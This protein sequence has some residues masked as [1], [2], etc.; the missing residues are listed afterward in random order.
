[1][2]MISFPAGV[3]LAARLEGP[4]GHA[5]LIS[6]DNTETCKGLA[7]LMARSLVCVGSGERPCDGCVACEKA[8]RVS[9]P[10][11][12]TVTPAEGKREIPVATVRQVVT[13]APTLPNEAERKVYIISPAEAMNPSA[14]NAILKVLEEP[15]S[16]VTFLLLAE[17]P[18][19]LL[20]TVR[21]RCVALTLTPAGTDGVPQASSPEAEELVEEFLTAFHAG[22][23]E[24]L[25]F[26]V[27]LEKAVKED[28]GIL[29]AFVE[30]GYAGLVAGLAGAAGTRQRQMRAVTLFDS[31]KDD[32]KFNVSPGHISGKMLATL[33]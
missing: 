33:I 22:G 26:C 17:N 5:Y 4:L 8:Q 23:L 25:Q 9:H 21:S 18:L 2:N 3:R 11:I 16:F 32:L 7:A 27:G 20:P 30:L 29:V 31:F 13:D 14:Q 15:P 12:M 19:A 28:R 10:D 24:L 6:G 1:M